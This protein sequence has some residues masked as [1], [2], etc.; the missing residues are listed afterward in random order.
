MI[1]LVDDFGLGG[2]R[3]GFRIGNGNIGVGTVSGA[4]GAY[5]FIGDTDVEIVVRGEYDSEKQFILGTIKRLD[6]F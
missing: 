4:D 5:D 1:P 6:E 2:G 3:P